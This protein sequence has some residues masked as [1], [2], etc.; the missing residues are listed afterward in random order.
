MIEG[1]GRFGVETAVEIA[2][3]LEPFHPAWFGEPV[4]PDSIDLLAEVKSRI[5]MR[6]AA[7]ERL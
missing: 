4:T 7:G 2:Q 6:V 5:S 1:H 3:A